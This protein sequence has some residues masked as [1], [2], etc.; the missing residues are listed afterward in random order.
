MC[1]DE[2]NFQGIIGFLG[3]AL[4]LDYPAKTYATKPNNF[5]ELFGTDYIVFW[6]SNGIDRGQKVQ[7]SLGN[8]KESR[9]DTPPLKINA[10]RSSRRV[11][12]AA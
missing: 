8:W 11:A 12:M 10:K 6:A 9:Y 4:G 7:T 2:T 3:V 1:C 5:L